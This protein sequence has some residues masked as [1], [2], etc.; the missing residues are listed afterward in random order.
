MGADRA[1]SAQRGYNSR[2]QKARAGY[3][4]SHPLCVK[5]QAQG[6]INPASIVD[7]ITPH[8]GDTTLFWDSANWQ[9]LCKPCHD[10]KTARED[11]GFGRTASDKPRQGC[12]V[13]GVPTD[14]RHHWNQ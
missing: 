5:C 6:R 13:D 1:S 7:H 10:S 4:R 3:L 12:T 9:P 2:W 14:K 8:K 11:G